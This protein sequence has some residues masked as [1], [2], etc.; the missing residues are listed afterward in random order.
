MCC[1]V[2]P[3]LFALFFSVPYFKCS[4]HQCGRLTH[5]DGGAKGILNQ[6]DFLVAHDVLRDYMQHFLKGHRLADTFF[7][8]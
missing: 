8:N 7:L 5:F 3:K 2:V 1:T 4:N 6:G